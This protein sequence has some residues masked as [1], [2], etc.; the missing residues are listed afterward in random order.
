[1]PEALALVKRE[2]GSEAIILGTRTTDP[3][4]IGKLMGKRRVEIT[5]A[6]PRGGASRQTAAA[7]TRGSHRAAAN[8]ACPSLAERAYPHF[9]ELVRGEVADRLAARLAHEASTAAGDG[10]DAR[11]REEIRKRLV[12]MIPAAGGVQLVDGKCR[13]VALVGPPGAGKT[14]TLA[15]LAAHFKLRCRKRVALISA[16]ARRLGNIDQLQRYA[17]II[18]VPLSAAHSPETLRQAVDDACEH[19]LVL[20]DTCGA[21][22]AEPARIEELAALFEP[23]APDEVHLVIPASMSPS[24]QQRAGRVFKRLGALRIVLTRLDEALG[25]GVV[26]NAM[27]RLGGK[28][29]Y[30]TSGQ[31]VPQDIEEA[32]SRRVSE[33]ILPMDG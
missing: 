2:F 14:T 8:S 33:L 23:S 29:S 18:G 1:M 11:I 9:L 4:G 16:D 3:H 6:E 32:C 24:V 21:S 30:L 28:L 26:L 13:T 15:K 17:E 12:E 20:I 19:D 10:N 31:N 27:E 5:A 25:F 7:A 22:L